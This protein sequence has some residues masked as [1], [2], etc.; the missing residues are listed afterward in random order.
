[1]GR[2]EGHNVK[3][4]GG[5]GDVTPHKETKNKYIKI[6]KPL[7]G[8]KPTRGL[9]YLN[10]G[11]SIPRSVRKFGYDAAIFGYVRRAF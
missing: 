5:R 7:R 9:E 4:E 3:R 8:R 2:W 11:Y 6:N 10:R 1:M